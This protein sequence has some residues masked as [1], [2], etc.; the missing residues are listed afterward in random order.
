[1]DNSIDTFNFNEV[2]SRVFHHLTGD[3]FKLGNDC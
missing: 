2:P 3:L 1:M